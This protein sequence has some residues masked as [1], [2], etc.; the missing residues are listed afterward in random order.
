MPDASES[1]ES[2]TNRCE[3][4]DTGFRAKQHRILIPRLRERT[5][6]EE[7]VFLWIGQASRPAGPE[8]SQA[9]LLLEYLFAPLLRH[10]G[11]GNEFFKPGD[12][13]EPFTIAGSIAEIPRVRIGAIYSEGRRVRSFPGQEIS[14]D[15]VQLRESALTTL[16]RRDAT[17][18]Y[19]VDFRTFAPLYNFQHSWVVDVP[20]ATDR[21]GE[22]HRLIFPWFTIVRYFFA[23]SSSLLNLLFMSDLTDQTA[24]NRIYDPSRSGWL[25]SIADFYGVRLEK[26]V[27]DKDARVAAHL[28]AYDR[29]RAAAS[30]MNRSLAGCLPGYP[31]CFFPV[32]ELVDLTIRGLRLRSRGNE[33][34]TMVLEIVRSDMR[35]AFT[36]RIHG[37]VLWRDNDGRSTR[38]REL[39]EAR[40]GGVLEQPQP[41]PPGSELEPMPGK[42][43][44]PE[45]GRVAL[46][47]PGYFSSFADDNSI[48]VL[49]PE[50]GEQETKVDN[51][52]LILCG[53]LKDSFTVAPDGTPLHDGE[54]RAVITGDAEDQCPT[55]PV[56]ETVTD[57]W[58][59]LLCEIARELQ[60]TKR[61]AIEFVPLGCFGLNPLSF[62]TP[63]ATDNTT[64]KKVAK[65]RRALR[66]WL[67]IKTSAGVRR[68]RYWVCQIFNVQTNRYF[69][70]VEFERKQREKSYSGCILFDERQG[71]R[72][73]EEQIETLM[74]GCAAK[75]GV[76]RHVK[77][78]P[79]Y[80]RQPYYHGNKPV[81]QGS[82]TAPETRKKTRPKIAAEYI[83][84][85]ENTLRKKTFQRPPRSESTSN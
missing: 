53:E 2:D 46:E 15:T 51:S 20:N 57:K 31:L 80:Q 47:D 32:E 40:D 9:D 48:P 76:W 18:Q 60:K 54:L 38:D 63:A 69:Y 62:C 10:S 55:L 41:P 72:L 44:D 35:S 7:A 33:P 79:P 70:I 65:E 77:F 19:L 34:Y 68:R 4:Q 73:R 36:P 64:D 21:D 82:G 75:R 42:A 25:T 37:V 24:T 59:R 71:C 81:E 30:S 50:K 49:K 3:N 14:F 6:E 84:T 26:W 43:G 16:M 11:S 5:E 83:D 1:G 17:D 74:M 78:D 29:F 67:T 13:G 23:G 66:R 61:Y 12:L 27:P 28:A 52:K 45:K 8:A 56:P 22:I 85:L 39:A 58:A